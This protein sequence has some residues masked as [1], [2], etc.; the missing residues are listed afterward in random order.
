MGGSDVSAMLD[1]D[2]REDEVLELLEISCDIKM[3]SS[4]RNLYGGHKYVRVAY[5]EFGRCNEGELDV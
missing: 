3:S 5:I 1:G 2:K 4:N